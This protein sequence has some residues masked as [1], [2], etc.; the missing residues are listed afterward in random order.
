MNSNLLANANQHRPRLRVVLPLLLVCL[1]VIFFS[2]QD[3]LQER[4]KRWPARDSYSTTET[5]TASETGLRQIPRRWVTPAPQFS[6]SK[7]LPDDTTLPE[8][9]L[10]EGDGAETAVRSSD[11]LP[12]TIRAA[13]VAAVIGPQTSTGAII[14]DVRLNG[15]PPPERDVPLDPSCARLRAEKMTTRFFVVDER[16]G[17]GDV[18]V[19]LAPAQ[20][21]PPLSSPTPLQP[22]LLDQIGCEFVPYV[23][24][25]QIGQRLL[26]RNSDPVLHNV[27]VSPNAFGNKGS[28]RAHPAGSP[29]F[30]LIFEAPEFFLPIKCDVHPWMFAYVCLFDHG[31]FEVTQPDGSFQLLN[32]PPGDY[33]LM[34]AHRKLPKMT[35]S[36]TVRNGE[37]NRIDFMFDMGGVPSP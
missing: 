14:G 24:G 1:A 29:D 13:P 37:T 21:T 22:V 28:N 2:I 33:L 34:A 31:Y 6:Q 19:A 25:L 26:V 11:P 3:R 17:L 27:H 18:V 30:E 20:N 7:S 12:I 5:E 9:S 23:L 15:I 8:D 36:I 35:K 4:S 16:G 10:P 32:V